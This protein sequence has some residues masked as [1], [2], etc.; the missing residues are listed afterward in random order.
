MKIRVRLNSRLQGAGGIRIFD[1]KGNLVIDGSRVQGG[2]T[3][4]ELDDLSDRIAAL[5]TL[6]TG[7]SRT[8]VTYCSGGS[9]SSKTILMS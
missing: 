9:S 5:E 3:T 4:E 7:L 6:T 1:T 8:T 2:A